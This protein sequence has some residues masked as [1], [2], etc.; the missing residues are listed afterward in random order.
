MLM[1][2]PEYVNFR[3]VLTKSRNAVVTVNNEAVIKERRLCVVG[4]S[5]SDCR[6]E[7]RGVS[8]DESAVL[9]SSQ[10]WLGSTG[11][12]GASTGSRWTGPGRRC[13]SWS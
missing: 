7:V 6:M 13:L 5:L 1:D 3:V 8:E 12:G 10:L 9:Q 11:G 4:G 2:G